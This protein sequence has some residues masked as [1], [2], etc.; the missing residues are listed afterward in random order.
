LVKVRWRA[1]KESFEKNDCSVVMQ[2]RKAFEQDFSA[3][4]RHF[5]INIWRVACDQCPFPVKM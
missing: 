4:D 3:L 5:I 1:G 2:Q